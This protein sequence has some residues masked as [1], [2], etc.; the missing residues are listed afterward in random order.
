VVK[1]KTLDTLN[2]LKTRGATLLRIRDQAPPILRR[3]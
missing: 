3:K 2:P 1:G